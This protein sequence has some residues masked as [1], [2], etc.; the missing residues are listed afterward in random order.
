MSALNVYLFGTF[1]IQHQQE[2]LHT[3][4]VGRARELLCYLL[5]HRNRP[6]SR[7]LLATVFWPDCT[8]AQSRKYLRQT[9]WLLQQSLPSSCT[10]GSSRVLLSDSESVQVNAGTDIW[11]DIAELENAFAPV[12]LLAGEEMDRAGANALRSAVSLYSGDLL[13]G[14]YQDWCLYERER[15]QNMYLTALEKLMSYCEF[16]HDFE[17]GLNHG[18]LILRQDRA[19]ERTHAN[20][21]RLRYLM[22]DRAGA[23]RQFQ[24]CVRALKQELDVTPA[25]RTVELYEQICA[26]RLEISLPPSVVPSGTSSLSL[27]VGHLER[28][29]SLLLELRQCV[30]QDLDVVN[31]ALSV[32]AASDSSTD[33]PPH[34]HIP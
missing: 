11:L 16:H 10:L 15:L 21:M 13:E 1:K 31:Q 34:R 14:W 7:E 2:D 12:R 4:Q 6:I 33:S 23:V 3:V 24:R 18:E 9:L 25:K 28:I 5:L 20:L 26:D 22:G 8:T 29:R 17:G 32:P 27:V 19:R 30:Q